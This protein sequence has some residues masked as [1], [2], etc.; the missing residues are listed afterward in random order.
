[1]TPF[2]L[3]ARGGRLRFVRCPKVALSLAGLGMPPGHREAPGSAGAATD[4]GSATPEHRRYA[5]LT[6]VDINRVQ[7]TACGGIAT[8]VCAPDAVSRVPAA[9]SFESTQCVACLSRHPMVS[10]RLPL[11]G[12]GKNTLPVQ[13]FLPDRHM[14]SDKGP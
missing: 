4:E 8:G 13:V 6:S 14:S 1:M 9:P 7:P 5:V 12:A 2:R 10:M 3:T 11:D